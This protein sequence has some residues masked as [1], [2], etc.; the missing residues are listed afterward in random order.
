MSFLLKYLPSNNR[1]ERIWKIAQVD[2]Q[3][4]YYNDRLGLLW[5]LIKPVFEAT[6]YFVAFKYLLGYG[7]S[8]FGLFL[9]AG[10]V[11]WMVF[12]EG[13]IRSI[14]LLMSKKY[15]IENIQFNHVDL[16]I[17]HVTS[18]FMG[19]SFNFTALFIAALASGHRMSISYI[20]LPIIFSSIFFITTGVSFV[21]SSLQ[22]FV[23]DIRHLWDMILLSGFW[24]S[25]VFFEAEVITDRFPFFDII[26][27]FLGIIA[28][29]RGILLSTYQID[30][31]IMIINLLTSIAILIF[32]F[33]IFKKIS[34]LA[35]EK[36]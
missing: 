2:F 16:Y 23:K 21:L 36:I 1:L 17:S 3:T 25:G 32:G 14:D 4:R 30:Y 35:I 15:L 22:P 33:F 12:A 9:F 29:V 18:V 10:I 26:N 13:T 24:L 28:N 11:S 7:K 27:P 6:L 31:K 5:A 19:F 20:F 34:L 8:G